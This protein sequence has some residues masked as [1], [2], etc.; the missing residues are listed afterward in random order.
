M[1]ST[2]MQNILFVLFNFN[3]KNIIHFETSKIR[4][5]AMLKPYCALLCYFTLSNARWFYLSRGKCWHSMG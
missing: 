1:K 4:Y 3:Y 5:S 2:M